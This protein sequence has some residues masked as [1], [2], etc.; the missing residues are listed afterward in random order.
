M[1]RQQNDPAT[2]A[3][4][5][6]G[7][8]EPPGNRMDQEEALRDADEMAAA[9]ARAND[10]EIAIRAHFRRAIPVARARRYP[11]ASRPLW[12][13]AG[14]NTSLRQPFFDDFVNAIKARLALIRGALGEAEERV[15][16][17][18]TLGSRLE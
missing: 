5:L 6:A 12:K 9:G 3:M 17:P 10:L 15:A 11:G 7:L 16:N 18:T 14:F 8:C 13:L 2:L 1:A 4:A